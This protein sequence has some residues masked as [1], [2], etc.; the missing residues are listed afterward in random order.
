MKTLT[1]KVTKHLKETGCKVI[2]ELGGN[3]YLINT[4]LG[5]GKIRAE[6]YDDGSFD[7]WEK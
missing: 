1:E 5:A 2:A 7:F 3:C 4:P 6:E